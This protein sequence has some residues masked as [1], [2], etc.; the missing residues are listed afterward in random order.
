MRD[1]CSFFRYNP[2]HPCRTILLAPSDTHIS[3]MHGGLSL[4][5]LQNRRDL[6]MCVS[7]HKSIY[8]QGKS[9]PSGFYVH[10]I[11]VTGRNTRAADTLSMKVPRTKTKLG[12][13]AISYRGPKFWKTIPRDLRLVENFATFKR[14][15]S[16]YIMNLFV[17]HPT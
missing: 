12:Q 15:L 7:C 9:S 2:S 1:I 14:L 8:F 4:L 3:D 11:A 5:S 16:L 10:V 17:N 6:H 13:Y